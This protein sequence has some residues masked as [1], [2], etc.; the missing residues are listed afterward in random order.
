M[1]GAAEDLI[2]LMQ[3]I[4]FGDCMVLYRTPVHRAVIIYGSERST[5]AAMH[6]TADT[7]R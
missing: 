1:T 4:E 6:M 7:V 3:W 5:V 2:G